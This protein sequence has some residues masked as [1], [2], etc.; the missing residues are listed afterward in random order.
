MIHELRQ[1]L[2]GKQQRPSDISAFVLPQCLP[3]IEAVGQRMAI[4]SAEASGVDASLLDVFRASIIK[5][6]P[7][8][9]SQHGLDRAAQA[10]LE[11]T[12]I[13]R[14]VPRLD[15]FVMNLDVDAYL[16]APIVS[17]ESWDAFERGL[18]VFGIQALASPTVLAKL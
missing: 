17:D 2:S 12:A 14:A 13:A 16:T 10:D 3:L 1:V 18:P 4:E 11:R 5:R 15:R 7:A 9:Y 8:W 6:D